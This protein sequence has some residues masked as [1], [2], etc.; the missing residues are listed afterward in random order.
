[1]PKFASCL[2]MMFTEHPLPDRIAAAADVGFTGVEIQRPYDQ[3]LDDLATK[4]DRAGVECTLLNTPYGDS[5]ATKFGRA[6]I[7][8][9]E[10]AFLDDLTL[11]M[12]SADALGCT[13]IHVMS[14]TMPADANPADHRATLVSNMREASD[15]AAERG[16][17]LHLEPLNHTDN[18][19]YFLVGQAMGHAI[20]DEIARDNVKVQFDLYHTQMAE[21][22][23]SDK[24]ETYLAK[25]A[26]IQFAGVPGRNEP[27]HG[28]MNHPFL[29]Y[30]IEAAGYDGWLGAEYKPRTGTLEGLGWAKPYGIG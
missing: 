18:P 23:V 19:G 8:G 11:A 22:F 28:E 17:T 13:R 5:E 25:S 12:D 10:A 30:M 29:F 26:Y 20:A 24:I 3:D 2:M 27:D 9:E 1:M 16:I 14:G 15:R 21:G 4:L 6:A 7:P